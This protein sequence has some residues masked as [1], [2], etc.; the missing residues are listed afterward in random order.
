L[1]QASVR[2][3]GDGECWRFFLAQE[4]RK[5]ISMG[6]FDDYFDPEQFEAGGG[7]FGRLLSLRPDLDPS[8]AGAGDA[9]PQD[10]S[11]AQAT[12]ASQAP[13]QPISS[14]PSL[15]AGPAQN[16]AMPDNSQLATP[17]S[18]VASQAASPSPD[19]GARLS[20]GLQSWAQTPVGSPFAALANGITG[21]N[22]AANG[23][24][25]G[26]PAPAATQ[27]PDLGDR[28]GAAFQSWAHT[29]VGS[30]FAGIAN[31]VTGFNTGQQTSAAAAAP[32]QARTQAPDPDN[33]QS[34]GIQSQPNTAPGNVAPS[35]P[36]WRI[37]A[38]RRPPPY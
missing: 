17:S 19:F 26:P 37:P 35:P 11:D 1:V 9:S 6:L 7:L 20:A 34:A 5:E 12:A 18:A 8:Q 27:S 15:N 30:P 14:Q 16:I 29:P 25:I 31:A 38:K 10:P 3:R 28:F 36:M 23:S 2:R 24:F 21:F 4:A 32:S 22:N 33:R 13:L